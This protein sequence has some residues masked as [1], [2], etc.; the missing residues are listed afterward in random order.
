MLSSVLQV[1]G[2]LAPQT[3]PYH[4]WVCSLQSSYQS[5]KSFG[6]GGGVC[7]RPS[8]KTCKTVLIILELNASSPDIVSFKV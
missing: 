5:G 7:V 8:K 6:M 4:F 2:A 1:L 3:A